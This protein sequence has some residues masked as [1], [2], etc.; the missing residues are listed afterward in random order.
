VSLPPL[1]VTV[2]WSSMLRSMG[3]AAPEDPRDDP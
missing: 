2:R 1:A 3:A